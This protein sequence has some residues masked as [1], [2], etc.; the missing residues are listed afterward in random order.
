MTR[1]YRNY[2]KEA[3]PRYR[4]PG[5]AVFLG[6]EGEALLHEG[7]GFADVA[8]ER[9][10]TP[11]TVFGIASLT[12]SFTALAVLQLVERGA[13][14]EEQR[15]ADF[16]DSFR[17]PGLDAIQLRHLMSNSSGLPP[18]GFRRNALSRDI[19]RDPSR[20]LLGLDMK[21]HLPPI[22]T[23]EQLAKAIAGHNPPLLGE[24]GT[25]F[26]YCNEGFGL[27]TRVIELAS[28]QD[29]VTFVTENILEPL[30]MRRSVFHPDDLALLPDVSNLYSYIGGYE[31][32][33]ETPGY[34]W[35]PSLIGTGYLRSTVGDLARYAA[36]HN[37]T[38]D[39]EL[40]SPE[41]LRRM[42]EPVVQVSPGVH[43]GYGLTIR[44]AQH[45][46]R[47]IHHGGSTK[48]VGSHLAMVPERG[49]T[50]IVLTNLSGCPV[51]EFAFTGVNAALG[52]PLDTPPYRH[53]PVTI[54]EAT[55]DSYAGTFSSEE[56]EKVRIEVTEDGQLLAHTGT[57]SAAARP[58]AGNA[59]AFEQNGSTI[60]VQFLEPA[61]EGGY[62][63]VRFGS[64]VLKREHA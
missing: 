9:P 32:V 23:V 47:V 34:Y 51:A 29:Y 30:G 53:P 56:F 27:L 35:A 38:S 15:V 1:S 28:G 49:V 8:Q 39:V 16:F 31:R 41:L 55:R 12:K 17:K 7:F 5:A 44:G 43:Y 26:S 62:R 19:E 20:E 21:D 52:L 46:V 64:R 40:L 60:L 36:V 50:S 45:G 57:T 2:L 14:R 33:E 13:L 25:V 48:G 22:D 59:L 11:D 42:S 58:V 10:V 54:D 4:V 3:L 63:T 24:P 6:R 37:G 61:A 18:M